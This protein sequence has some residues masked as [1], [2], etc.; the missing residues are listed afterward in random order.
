[1]SNT[2]KLK[3]GLDIKLI[4]EAEKL[5]VDAKASRSVALKPTDFHGLVPRVIVKPGDAVK[6]GEVV[7]YDKYNEEVKI[8]SPIAGTL[9]EIVRG[10]KRRILEVRIQASGSDDVIKVEPAKPE[11]LSREEVKKLLLE[12]GL[13]PFIKQ[14]PL[15]KVA[16]PDIPRKDS[17]ITAFDSSPLGPDYDYNVHGRVE[18]LRLGIAAIEK[19][20]V[21]KVN[22]ILSA[23]GA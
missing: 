20:T 3:K 21:G 7:F 6:R 19:S 8:V 23:T 22:L 11:T 1:M 17:S 14:R 13:W 9:T 12:N 18:W 2:V 10:E 4:G 15:D 5:I 16:N